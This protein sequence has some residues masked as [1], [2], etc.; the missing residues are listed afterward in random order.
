MRFPNEHDSDDYEYFKHRLNH[1]ISFSQ[2]HGGCNGNN[3]WRD[4]DCRSKNDDYDEDD[5]ISMKNKILRDM[6]KNGN[7]ININKR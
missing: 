7:V 4:E 1:P 5:Q 2:K 6:N 3:S